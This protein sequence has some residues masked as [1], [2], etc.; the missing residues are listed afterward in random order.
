MSM[1]MFCCSD[2]FN[3]VSSICCNISYLPN[4]AMPASVCRCVS[5]RFSVTIEYT[6]YYVRNRLSSRELHL[7][8]PIFS[9]LWVN[10]HTRDLTERIYIRNKSKYKKVGI[11]P[12][13]IVWSNV[14]ISTLPTQHTTFIYIYIY[15]ELLISTDKIVV[16]VIMSQQLT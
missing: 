12:I 7:L 3:V 16:I 10:K 4:G 1:E 15:E 5:R 2:W 14:C 11:L 9:G 8:N 6:N 13:R